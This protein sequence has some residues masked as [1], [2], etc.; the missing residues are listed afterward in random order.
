VEHAANAVKVGTLR[1][2]FRYPVKSMLGESLQAATLGEKGIPWDRAWAIRDEVR[3]GIQGGKKIAGL[4]RCAARYPEGSGPGE[5]PA[6]EIELPNGDVFRADDPG[7]AKRI[8]EVVGREVT[9]W[10][11]QPAEALDHYR[12]SAPDNPDMEQELRAIFARE[13]DEPLPDLSS[14]PPEVFQFESPPGTYFDAFPLLVLSQQSLDTLAAASPN[15]RIDVRRFRPNLLVDIQGAQGLPEQEWIGKRLKIGNAILQVVMACMRCVMTTRGFADL[16]EDPEVMR[17]LV[18]ETDGNLGV[19]A[20]VEASG[21]VRKGDPIE[22][23][24]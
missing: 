12:R 16:P 2:I 5:A 19:Y 8:G 9:L 14:F 23:L 18:K 6:P 20:S 13:P 7:A 1:E 24:D 10:P 21:Q 22:L 11:L 15:S 4:M 3:G 17:K